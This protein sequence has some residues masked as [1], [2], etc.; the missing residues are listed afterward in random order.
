[1]K[2]LAQCAF[3]ASLT[4]IAG[5]AMARPELATPPKRDLPYH[6]LPPGIK[7]PAPAVKAPE[8]GS[9]SLLGAMT[10]LVGGILVVRGRQ[11]RG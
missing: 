2:T 9:A 3:V 1:M 6:A 8:L 4:L 5:L 10:L 7:A 11:A